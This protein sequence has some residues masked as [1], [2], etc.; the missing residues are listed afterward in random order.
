[1]KTSARCTAS[2]IPPFTW[3]GLVAVATQ[4]FMKSMPLARP[5]W[6]VPCSSTPTMSRTPLDCKILIVAVPAAPTPVTTTRKDRRGFLTMRNALS[7]AARTTT[8]VPC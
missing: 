7:N 2:A 5:R 1:M 3:R 4:R 6:M 8:A